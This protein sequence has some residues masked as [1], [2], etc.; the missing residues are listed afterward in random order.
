MMNSA[1]VFFAIAIANQKCGHKTVAVSSPQCHARF[2]GAVTGSAGLNRFSFTIEPAWL[3]GA[4]RSS[5]GGALVLQSR[6]LMMKRGSHTLP[7]MPSSMFLRVTRIWPSVAAFAMALL[8][9]S[10]CAQAQDVFL[11][12]G[13]N[14]Y[15]A[16]STS[17][18]N[19][20][21]VY[22]DADPAADSPIR[23]TQRSLGYREVDYKAAVYPTLSFA[24]VVPVTNNAQI[25]YDYSAQSAK[26]A[27]VGFWAAKDLPVLIGPDG[28][29]YITDGHH[30]TAGYLH[31]T[32]PVRQL[33]PGLN[34]VVLGHVVANYFDAAVGPQPVTDA[35]WVARAAENNAMLFGVDGD[36]LVLP[37]EDG[38]AVLQPILPSVISMPT[39][40]SNLTTNGV[41]A[42]FNSTLRSLTWAL[43]DGVV[44]SA[45][46]GLGKKIVGYK[47]S[48]PGSAVDINFV[49]FYWADYLRHRLSWDD[50]KS[51]SPVTVTNSDGS[52]IQAPLG[53]FAA[54]AN[55]IALARSEVF[56][57]Q[58][59]RRLINY[60]NTGLFTPNTV[61][62][63]RGSL[64]NGL[65]VAT[66]TYHLYLLDDSDIIGDISPSLLSTNV[67]HI[68]TTSG[69]TLSNAVVGL[70][71]L[72]LNDGPQL[73]TSWKDVT[74]SNTTLRIPAGKG[75]VTLPGNLR[76]VQNTI[77][78]GGGLVVNGSLSN[79]AL[80][81]NS[82]TLSGSGV[83]RGSVTLGVG[84]TLAPG[85]DAVAAITLQ[86]DVKL[87]GKTVIQLEKSG[88][89]VVISDS[90][91][92]VGTLT[93]GGALV[94]HASGSSL[95]L[96]DSFT[97][98]DATH[99]VGAFAGYDLPTLDSG[100]SWDTT[101][102]P[103]NGTLRV[104]GVP[105][106]VPI[107]A[108]VTASQ[109]VDQGSTPTLTGGAF[110]SEPISYH[111]ILATSVEA[112]ETNH[113]ALVLSNIQEISQGVY[114][115]VAANSLGSVTSAPVTLTVNQPPT[116]TPISISSSWRPAFDLI[117]AGKDADSDPLT[118]AIV[119]APTKGTLSGKGARLVYQPL[120][121][122]SGVDSFSYKAN[123]GRLDS[124]PAVVAITLQG[125]TNQG[126]VGVGRIAADTF[127][128][129]GAGLDTLGGIGSGLFYDPSTWM[130]TGD[131]SSGFTYQGVAY[132]SPDRGFGD[133]GQS[134][135]PR[136]QTL[137]LAVTP[138]YGTSI[139]AQTQIVMSNS[140]TLL[141]S[142]GGTPFTGWDSDDATATQFPQ[143]SVGSP[144]QGRRSLDPEGIVKTADG[145]YFIS[146]E[147]GPFIY[148]FDA[149]G[150]LEYELR[151][152]AALLP[153][154]GAFP[155]TNYF[156]A[157]NAPLSGRRNNR[158]LEGLSLTPDGKR[159]FTVLQSPTLQDGG[160]GTSGRNTRILVFD[161]D[162]DST[163]YKKPIAEYLY[164]LTL[165]GNAQTNRHT[166]ISEIFA[167]NR[168]QVLVLERDAS[169]LG[170]GTN[171]AATYKRI[172]LASTV[173]ASNIINTG[174]DLER[175]APNQLSLSAGTLPAGVAAMQR[176][177]L[178][179]MLD[180]IQLAR[181]GLNNSTNQ[182]A[183]TISEKWESLALMPLNDPTATNDFLLLVMNDN[184]FKASTVYHNGVV[185][186][187]NAPP[188][189]NMMFAYRLS[190]PTYAASVPANLLPTVTLTAPTNSVLSSPVNFVVT[191]NANDPD[192][193]ITKVEFWSGGAKL[194]EDT[195]F[196]FQLSMITPPVG[197]FSAFAIAYDNEGASVTSV[198]YQV[199]IRAENV[200]PTIALTSPTSGLILNAPGNFA[201]TAIGSDVDG[202][203]PKVDLYRGATKLAT[204]A[205][206]TYS[207]ALS[208]QPLGTLSFVGVA[209]DSQGLS[210]TSA[211]VTVTI[212][213]NLN[214]AAMTLQILHASDL[215]AGV[216]AVS[217]APAFSAVLGALKAQYPT[218]TLIVSSGDNYIPGPFFN[219]SGDPLANLG[220]VAG[221]ADIVM[222]DA[223]GFQAAAFGNH[224]F[225]AGT[226]Q[227]RSLLIR[228]AA[229]GY[230]GTAFPYLSA[231]L[232][233]ATDDNLSGLV[234][235]DGQN[236]V[237][238]SNR[239]ARSAVVSVAGQLI[240]IVGVTTPDLRSIS[241]PG[242]VTVSAD[243]VGTVQAAVNALLPLGVN[244]IVVLA[245]LQQYEL[246]F[247]LAQQLRDVDVV[248][249][250]GSHSIFAKPS[251]LLRLGDVASESYPVSFNS[252][253]TEPTL[254]VNCGPNYRYVGRLVLT[255]STNGII[256]S[257][258]PV[259]GAYA[260]DAAGVARLGNPPT[261]S[262]VLNLATNLG[263]I[264]SQK[265]SVLFGST[266]V[267]L[268]GLRTSVRTEESNLGDLSADAN[269]WRARQ[270]DP[271]VSLSLKNG[272]GIR[273]S[274]GGVLSV[275]SS[276][277]Y[278]PPIANRPAKKKAGR[279]SQLDIE[280]ALRL[281]NGLSI[282]TLTA[283]Q[284]RDTMEWGVAAVAPRATPGQ[285]PQVSG[286][287]FSY[288]PSNA[289]LTYTKLP[290]GTITGIT[291]AGE[292]V[293]TL[294][295]MRDD[296]SLDLVVQ[297]GVLQGDAS[298]TF[299]LVT[300]DFLAG[301]GDSY[302]PLTQ[303]TDRMNLTEGSDRSFSAEGGE[304]WAFAQYMKVIRTYAQS[305]TPASQDLRIQNL[306]L[307]DDWV[308]RPM[309]IRLVPGIETEVTFS[310]LPAARYE[311]WTAE[312]A[313]GPWTRLT[314]QS[315]LGDGLPQ[316]YRDLT[317]HS[318]TR[319]YQVQRLE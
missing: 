287:W 196:P 236:G 291:T 193:L 101:Q 65:A 270:T 71:T 206:P 267:Y 114:Y 293:R 82:G 163:T 244:K 146:D 245:H 282:L 312:E 297:E 243:L 136:V 296:G 28:K 269:L 198:V 169:G 177:D 231:N 11:K 250:G 57:D 85:G 105:S 36:L 223:M 8:V 27:T 278:V 207:L 91:V 63:A 61:N 225:D 125:F 6:L 3:S 81:V 260:T 197:P 47:K 318:N 89:G 142:Y 49:E 77:L 128:A 20:S 107:L 145:G 184:D 210:T 229:F 16:F 88:T 222:M 307:R 212:T 249:A 279:I 108:G 190:L 233:F 53:F 120:L 252:A 256:T 42:M 93:F 166:P 143:S 264:I 281:N 299:R 265:D 165:N 309:I 319:Y 294:V 218:N 7:I 147:Y 109:T 59:G 248:V 175:G 35:W 161:L 219:A 34:R 216:D 178:I 194:T 94:V 173:G 200:A 317:P 254:V 90:L 68:N 24:P 239:I 170:T 290:D 64:S 84:G 215:E 241:S 205:G 182:D 204:L 259:S 315:I 172:V 75:V 271:H 280:N 255:F 162:P 247:G 56:R 67:L 132:A 137:Q 129:R 19:G 192:G 304:Q 32:S 134:Y 141:L 123:D 272:G 135:I 78:S 102:L 186:G 268:N 234:A 103:V 106:M 277:A 12:V 122:A 305:D 257:V 288:N 157:T 72:L 226:A 22:I 240:G 111:W 167:L 26:T 130:Q 86:G 171:V 38:Y 176:F 289:P 155:G 2:C 70:T 5:I 195:T 50:T 18:T 181:F 55:G 97:V 159:L 208:N 283:Q 79:A 262:V 17:L 83:V 311:V 119:T 117:L 73:K 158:G 275:G 199:M 29:A 13:S 185:V 23:A 274:I 4:L 41:I 251:D 138:Y 306:S 238:L 286:I 160:A 303:G 235:S 183:N 31:S 253:A 174:Y 126:L 33:L 127:D 258:L 298:R 95:V 220:G 292:R 152:P 133:G 116:V 60:T 191:A 25:V 69:R 118:F 104:G 188:V 201:L 237:V 54:T 189:D 203:A 121:G 301:G 9:S 66:D 154:L 62:W 211:P 217:D 39:T 246:E 113:A 153:K 58:H 213:K 168:Q 149:T 314:S 148:K 10:L 131:A 180:P 52:V 92:G 151:P 179:D 214:T 300:L 87:N 139:V 308:T 242:T 43:A 227:V 266:Q 295:A 140:A 310:T 115:L 164:T 261:N 209:T 273:D 21:W 316:R 14:V 224:E 124:S 276:V 230:P 263:R 110:G 285:F 150:V 156:T 221:R 74:V 232:N 96:G 46:D 112:P 187:S 100:L 228:D 98:F 202:L 30:T 284:L 80:L 99:Y 40:P 313:V 302:F 37:G 15:S 45:T 1:V 76:V 48:A 144:G 51:G 44:A